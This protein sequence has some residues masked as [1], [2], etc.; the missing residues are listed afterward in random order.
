[1][2][3]PFKPLCITSTIFMLPLCAEDTLPQKDTTQLQV[4]IDPKARA[5][6]YVEA[7]NKLRQEK[8]AGKVVFVCKDG[9]CISNIIDLQVMEHGSLLLLRYNSSQGIKFRVIALEDIQ[10]LEHL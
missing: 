10:R 4:M 7:F 1:M 9:S 3:F 6:D 5:L 8:T 2:R